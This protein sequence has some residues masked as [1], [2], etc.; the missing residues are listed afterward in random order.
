HLGGSNFQPSVTS[1]LAMSRIVNAGALTIGGTSVPIVP[2]GPQVTYIT[3]MYLPIY[4]RN[5]ALATALSL[6]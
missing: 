4:V 1:S 2:V 5:E 3:C 6:Y